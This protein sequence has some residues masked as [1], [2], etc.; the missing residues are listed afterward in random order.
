MIQVS[1]FEPEPDEQPDDDW[2]PCPCGAP[3]VKLA[4]GGPRCADCAVAVAAEVQDALSSMQDLG[5]RT[6]KVFSVRLS[7]TERAAIVREKERIG[8]PRGLG[9]WLVW[10]ALAEVEQRVA[11][12]R[13]AP[14]R[15][16][17][18]FE[19]PVILD[20]CAGTG[21]WSLPYEESD[22]YAVLCVDLQQSS[23]VET[24]VCPGNVHGILAAPP[25]AEFS[26]AKR[27]ARDF[28]AGMRTVNAC[29]RIVLQAKLYGSLQ[30]WA[31]E[32]PEGLL[33][34]WLGPPQDAH[35]PCDYGDP[36]TKRTWVWGEFTRPIRG[37][38]VIP[39]SGMPGANSAER[40][41]TPPGFAAAF[42]RAN[43]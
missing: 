18:E 33:S 3:A 35:E 10:R 16:L 20:L 12:L 9:P 30:W 2:C 24:F 13:P 25:C 36:W 31:L 19:R 22:R 7:D 29:L 40:A 5:G 11:P 37:P 28:A 15:E 26:R 1:L 6:G 14:T 8:G 17:T 39:T 27:G 32:N 34:Q 21:A 41:R 42:F 23:D 38:H 4:P 43:P